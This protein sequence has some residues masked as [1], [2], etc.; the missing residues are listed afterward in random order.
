MVLIAGL[1]VI[2]I[3]P[4][5]HA[6]E[7]TNLTNEAIIMISSGSTNYPRAI[8][9]IDEALRINSSEFGGRS[10]AL[11]LKSYCLIQMGNYSEALDTIDEA[12]SLEES[13]VL[14]N[15]KGYILYKEGRY[16]ESVD[17]YA[18][19]LKIDPTYTVAL[20]N[21]GNSLMELKKYNDAVTSYTAAFA[22]DKD[23]H[24][25]S[26]PQQVKT[27]NN[28]G[29]AYYQLGKYSESAMA[30]QNALAAEPG[31]ATA[32]AGLSMASQ[33]VQAGT[34]LLTGGIIVIL[35]VV[36]GGSYYLLKVRRKE[37]E[38]RPSKSPKKSRNK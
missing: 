20:I 11:E 13:A 29:D 2:C 16:Q 19:A 37:P 36:A 35:V 8:A 6:D 38:K 4:A 31:N 27:Y 30:Y 22:A 34:L 21:N 17:A 3:I 25:L 26:I 1:F 23:V 10:N 5:V 32:V 28:L 9:L 7:S 15:N 18:R 24:A 33:R 14:W 12:L